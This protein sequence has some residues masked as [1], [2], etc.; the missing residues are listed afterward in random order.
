MN[1]SI[2]LHAANALMIVAYTVRDVLWLR[3][4][5]VASSLI[6]L[7]YFLL[8]PSP[9]WEPVA[10]SAVFAT[11]NLVQ[12]WRLIL[13]RRPVKLT[14]EEEDLRRLAFPEL[15]PRKLLR[16][17]DIGS[18]NTVESGTCLIEMGAVCE[19]ISLIVRGKAKVTRDG[20]PL[21][22]L[23]PGEIAGTAL[24]LNGGAADV[25]AV[26]VEQV[27]SVS[28]ERGSLQRYLDADPETRTIFQRCL[29][30]DLADK[31]VRMGAGRTDWVAS[32]R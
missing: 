9:Q 27:R 23:G 8:Q 17:L 16:L 32:E 22:E 14:P 4:F 31:V 28:W 3:L 1:A 11:I 20:Q 24:F 5:A 10:W 18:W 26:T 6:S 13:E 19:V 21:G 12:S 29:V 7:P 30:R 25:E 15:S 2:Y